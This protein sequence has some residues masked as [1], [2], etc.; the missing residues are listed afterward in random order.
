M[1]VQV[2]EMSSEVVSHL[3]P[4]P[5]DAGLPLIGH[6]FFSM[7]DPVKFSMARYKKYGEI[8]WANMFGIKMVS[9][10]GADANQFVFMNRGD[11]FSNN[12]GWDYFIGKFFHRGIMLLDFE[13]HRHHRRIMQNAFKKP[14]LVEYLKGMNPGIDTGIKKW[15]PQSKFEMFPAIKQLTLDLATEIFMGYELG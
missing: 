11:I 13:E 15:Q 9:M 8:S 4:I 7:M 3:K 10:F 5:G 1:V 12:Q 6:T 14:V 2:G